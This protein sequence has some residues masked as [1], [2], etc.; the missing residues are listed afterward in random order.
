LHVQFWKALSSVTG[1]ALLVDDEFLSSKIQ[2]EYT[3]LSFPEPLEI[4][5]F[6][7]HPAITYCI[8][9][10]FSIHPILG[11]TA[12]KIYRSSKIVPRPVGD[13]LTQGS[14]R[15]SKFPNALARLLFLQLN[16]IE[17]FNKKRKEWVAL[18]AKNNLLSV[19][20]KKE[21]PLLRVPYLSPNKSIII[22][23]AKKDLIYLGDWYSR[24]IDPESISLSA[25]KY[26]SKSCPIAEKVSKEIINLPVNPT[27]NKQSVTRV[28]KCIKQYESE[29]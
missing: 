15:A 13:E 16:S 14:G 18:Y 4:I 2:E 6:L 9:L 8:Y 24:A 26:K 23:K 27:L 21:I 28:I 1:G 12:T 7:L 22:E 29:I 20:L 25:L 10:L 3:N 5:R 19:K 17:E 11:K